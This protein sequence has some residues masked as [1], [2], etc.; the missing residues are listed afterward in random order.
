M[1]QRSRAFAEKARLAEA[2]RGSFR[3]T[4]SQS[5][6]VADHQNQLADKMMKS[7]EADSAAEA[8]KQAE[9]ALDRIAYFEEWERWHASVQAAN[10]RASTHPWEGEPAEPPKPSRIDPAYDYSKIPPP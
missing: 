3:I 10:E 9:A 6:S 2:M 4:I 1:R 8:K 7:N 5:R